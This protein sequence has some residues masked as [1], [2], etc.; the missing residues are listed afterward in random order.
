LKYCVQAWRPHL[1]KDT[2]LVEKVQMRAT[3]MIEECIGKL[4]KERLDIVSLTTLESRRMRADLI[5]V[6]KM[7]KRFEGIDEKLFF[8][9]HISKKKVL[10]S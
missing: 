7:L 3:K 9:R 6:F 1:V 5:E 2:V 8:K 10:K 4:C